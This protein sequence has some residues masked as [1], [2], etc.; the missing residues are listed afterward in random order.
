M[1]TAIIPCAGL[2]R[3]RLLTM[4]LVLLQ[5]RSAT[6][7]VATARA[8]HSKSFIY[9]C[10]MTWPAV[11]CSK[12]DCSLLSPCVSTCW[13]MINPCNLLVRTRHSSYDA[14]TAIR[15]GQYIGVLTAA[16]IAMWLQV[17]TGACTLLTAAQ[18]CAL[19]TV[20]L[21]NWDSLQ[22]DTLEVESC[23]TAVTQQQLTVASTNSTWTQRDKV[24]TQ[25]DKVKIQDWSE[26]CGSLCTA[27]LR[28]FV[29]G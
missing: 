23:V 8:L 5:S 29:P 18:Q 26:S 19:I 3:Q 13:T 6:I 25:G 1:G 2:K 24:T 11:T 28:A 22:P 12:V 21:C 4:K 9:T 10:L 16:C 17:C 27:V 14:H 15:T 20:P 7:V